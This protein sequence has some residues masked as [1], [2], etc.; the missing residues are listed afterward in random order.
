VTYFV[1]GYESYDTVNSVEEKMILAVEKKVETAI[2]GA[3]ETLFSSTAEAVVSA[4]AN[5]AWDFEFDL[6]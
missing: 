1:E 3:D 4:S 2:A 5:L 6:F